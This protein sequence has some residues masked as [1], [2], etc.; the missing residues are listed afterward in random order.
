MTII[1]HLL[2]PDKT[3]MNARDIRNNTN[4]S[5]DNGNGQSNRQQNKQLTN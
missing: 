1:L 3:H 2:R 5:T 4:T